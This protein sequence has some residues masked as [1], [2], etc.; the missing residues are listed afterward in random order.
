VLEER[1]SLNKIFEETARELA[2]PAISHPE[3]L[4][5]IKQLRRRGSHLKTERSFFSK[6]NPREIRGSF[7]GMST[8]A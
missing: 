1:F 5:I 7:F 4:D 2:Y 8:N 6:T 3:V